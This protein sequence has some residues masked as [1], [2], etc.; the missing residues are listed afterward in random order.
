MVQKEKALSCVTGG[1][2]VIIVGGALGSW[3]VYLG[4]WE[5]YHGVVGIGVRCWDASKGLHF[6]FSSL[7]Q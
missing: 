4:G 5:T 6:G 3:R 7:V 1:K 2:Q